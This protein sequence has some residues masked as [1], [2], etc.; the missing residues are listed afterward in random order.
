[1]TMVDVKRETPPLV[2]AGGPALQTWSGTTASHTIVSTPA[3]VSPVEPR[4]V[5]IVSTS[6]HPNPPAYAEW[7]KQGEL[8]VAGDL[9]TPPDLAGYVKD[10]GGTYLS[11]DEQERWPF[12]DSIGWHTIQRRNAAIMEAYCRRY[13]YIVT[14]D[15]DNFPVHDDWVKRHAGH[16]RGEYPRG[17]PLI[18]Y[19]DGNW[20]DTGEFV[21]PRVRQRGTPLDAV[22]EHRL[23]VTDKPP[24]VVVS[25]AQVLGDPDCDAITRITKEPK[26][27]HVVSDVIPAVWQYAAFNSQATLWRGDWAPLM[28]CLPYA[29]RYDDIFA[30]V[31]A[32]RLMMVHQL[33]FYCGTPTVRQDR[34]EHN[35]AD[36]LRGEIYGMRRMRQ[37]VAAIS[38]AH[39]GR[40]ASLP[41]AYQL[42]ADH[43]TKVI[44]PGTYR[45]MCSWSHTWERNVSA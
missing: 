38:G 17:N 23:E 44:N 13:D 19:G 33:S 12:S 28:A 35:F 20:V 7:A 34:N 32:K 1:M 45:F 4:R 40:T 2:H 24:P 31:I 42:L 37:F 21:E 9:N 41:L 11:P 25:T 16:I 18:A 6:I 29:W 5:G 39:V 10:L 3:T 30:S 8:I 27:T 14:V 26:V 15:D 22:F 43:L 36:D